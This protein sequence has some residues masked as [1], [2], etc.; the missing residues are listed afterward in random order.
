M[1]RYDPMSLGVLQ[2][3]VAGNATYQNDIFLFGSIQRDPGTADRNDTLPTAA[4]LINSVAPTATN[5]PLGNQYYVTLANISTTNSV[6]ILTNTGVTLVGGVTL[7]PSSAAELT[8]HITSASTCIVIVQNTNTTQSNSPITPTSIVTS[9][10]TLTEGPAP[11]GA[12][13]SAVIYD[14]STSHFLSAKVAGNTAQ[15]VALDGT[16]QNFTAV[17]NFA[18]AGGQIAITP[19]NTGNAFTI[20]ATANPASPVAITVPDPGQ[21]AVSFVTTATPGLVLT[22]GSTTINITTHPGTLIGI[23]SSGGAVVLTLPNVATAK[24]FKYSFYWKTAGTNSTIATPAA[25]TLNGVIINAGTS[26]I[27][28]PS[29]KQTLTFVSGSATTGD[30][31]DLQ[32]DGVKWRC[33]AICTVIGGITVA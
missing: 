15:R 8:L 5:F 25:N 7:L 22:N 12:S 2:I 29:N 27:P 33:M 1:Y 13:G 19:N 4:N 6:T 32:S 24:G 10:I 31:V 3:T 11:T 23:D 16:I 17:Q 18:A 9:K 30:W 21:A 28:I 14:D 26:V 20:G